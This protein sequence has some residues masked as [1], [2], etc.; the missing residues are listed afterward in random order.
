[1]E[2]RSNRLLRSSALTAAFIVA[3]AVFLGC[4]DAGGESSDG[5]QGYVTENSTT[6][7][8]AK[9]PLTK[10]RFVKR[11]NEIC[12]KAWIVVLDNWEEHTSWQDRK[13]SRN[14]RFEDAV[15]GSLL[16][17]IVFHIFDN[18]LNLGAPPGETEEVEEIVGPFQIAVELG[19][20]ERWRAQTVGEVASQFEMYNRRARAYGLDDCLV[21]QA[22][23]RLKPIKSS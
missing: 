15:R 1:M 19:W 21:D 10:A 16:N 12:R 4:G 7:T 13:L 20:K 18:I 9:P 11:V 17:G 3:A 2:E 14:D 6:M 23:M 22:H 5:R 8:V